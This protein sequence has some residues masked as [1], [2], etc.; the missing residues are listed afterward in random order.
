MASTAACYLA[1]VV[2]RLVF[3]FAF[4]SVCGRVLPY[5][6]LKI[7]PR[8]VRLSP[9][10]TSLLQIVLAMPPVILQECGHGAHSL[11]R[12]HHALNFVPV[13]RAC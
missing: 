5:E 9:L 2:F 7:L 12:Q 8:F 6:F 10:P 3:V 1:G 13:T 4:L 11:V